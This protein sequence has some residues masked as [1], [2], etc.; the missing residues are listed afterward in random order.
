[1]SKAGV[2]HPCFMVTM[3]VRGARMEPAG[4][5]VRIWTQLLI[6]GVTLLLLHL[7]TDPL[8][9]SCLHEP[10]DCPLYRITLSFFYSEGR[11]KELVS[12]KHVGRK[13]NF[14]LTSSF[15]TICSFPFY[16]SFNSFQKLASAYNT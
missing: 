2:E 14:L 11:V 15:P 16:S 9:S 4:V 6:P 7:L 8:Q 3:R 10:F 1:M 13:Q 12:F 5:F